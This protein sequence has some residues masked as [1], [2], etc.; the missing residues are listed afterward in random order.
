MVLS[1]LNFEVHPG[2]C[3]GIVGETGAGK[4]TLLSL[5]GRLYDVTKGRVCVDGVDVR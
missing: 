4:S 1:D 2:E 5:I 3:L